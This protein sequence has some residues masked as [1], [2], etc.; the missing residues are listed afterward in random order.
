MFFDGIEDIKVLLATLVR[1]NT[2]SRERGGGT[3][4]EIKATVQKYIARHDFIRRQYTSEKEPLSYKV[5]IAFECFEK[6]LHQWRRVARISKTTE[7]R[8][9]KYR[10]KFERT[11]SKELYEEVQKHEQN[12]E[13]F[14][15]KEQ[16][17]RNEIEEMGKR[18]ATELDAKDS[19]VI[20]L[21][22]RIRYLEGKPMSTGAEAHLSTEKETVKL[23]TQVSEPLEFSPGQFTPTPDRMPA[24]AKPLYARRP[25]NANEQAE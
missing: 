8:E 5:S 3:L 24:R 13:N 20:S 7:D 10:E 19:L 16:E 9:I 22:D 1:L 18:H 23:L 2:I 17:Y 15:R 6:E 21:R 4:D 12:V 25:A 11:C 14:R